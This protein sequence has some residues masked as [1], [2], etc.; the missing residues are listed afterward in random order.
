[1][2]MMTFDDVDGDEDNDDIARPHDYQ[3]RVVIVVLIVALIVKLE[4]VKQQYMP[5]QYNVIVLVC[6]DA[7]GDKQKT[8]TGHYTAWW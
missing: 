2:R 8:H 5:T 1:M 4:E 6:N 3:S 7:V